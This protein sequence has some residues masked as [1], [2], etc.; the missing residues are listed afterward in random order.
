MF[1]VDDADIEELRE[2]ALL[3]AE[4]SETTSDLFFAK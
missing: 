1:P 3:A 4:D 2:L